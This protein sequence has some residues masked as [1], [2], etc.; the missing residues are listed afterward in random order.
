MKKVIG[1][2]AIL[3]LCM[4]L[5]YSCG[6]T[7]MTD[8]KKDYSTGGDT[9]SGAVE[10]LAVEWTAG[11]VTIAYHADN[12]VIL[13]EKANRAIPED[14]K[15]LWKLD[16]TTLKIEYHRPGLFKL[17]TLAKDLTII[18]PEGTKLNKAVIHATSADLKVPSLL[19][20][21]AVFET[22]SGNTDAKVEAKN[23]RAVSTS[24]DVI[25]KL[26]GRQDS[27]EISA[28][29]GDLSLTAEETA[30]VTAHSTSGRISAE[31][32]DF[33][34][35]TADTTS[36]GIAV[37]TGRF[38]E[39]KLEA[40][41]GDISAALPQDPGFSGTIDTTSGGINSRI[42]LENSGN[43]Y[44]CGDGSAKLTIRATSGNVTITPNQ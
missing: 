25:L 19:A 2:L 6:A 7:D 28:T 3:V 24:G 35:I 8:N 13:E 40:T 39:M 9:I 12:T 4:T 16:G 37:K 22:T 20:E 21:E 10:T 43:H 23:V 14:E 29:S 18:L 41:S 42:P 17:T 26:A 27:V 33:G 44:S 11:S 1:L 32:K 31:A 5:L 36:G 15:L 38:A 30:K 34:T